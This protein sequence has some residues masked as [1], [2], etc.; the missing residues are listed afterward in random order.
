MAVA[1]AVIV[2]AGGAAVFYETRRAER[3]RHEILNQMRRTESLIRTH[4][5]RL[6]MSVEAGHVNPP[7]PADHVAHELMMRD[8][9]RLGHLIDFRME[10][11][12]VHVSGDTATATYRIQGRAKPRQ[13]V[14][15]F[16]ESLE[17]VPRSGEMRFERRSG[18]WTMAGHRLID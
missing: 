11:L 7:S 13:A 5:M 9:D 15:G 2:L 16:T 4:D 8:F 1:A 18:K 10:D 14:P 17:S 6:W 3:D 12:Q